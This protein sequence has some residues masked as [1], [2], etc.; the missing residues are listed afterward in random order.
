VSSDV[1]VVVVVVVVGEE[2][3]VAAVV[4][5]AD[6]NLWKV[7]EMAAVDKMMRHYFAWGFVVILELY[8]GGGGRLDGPLDPEKAGFT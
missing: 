6:N 3:L 8:T 2:E 5:A 1:V 7:E 4:E